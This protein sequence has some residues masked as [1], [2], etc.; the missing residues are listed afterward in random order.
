MTTLSTTTPDTTLRETETHVL[1]QRASR[2]R[3]TFILPTRKI[4]GLM[5]SP[6]PT[7][8]TPIGGNESDSDNEEIGKSMLVLVTDESENRSTP[9]HVIDETKEHNDEVG[10]TALTS[11]LYRT[12]ANAPIPRNPAS[13]ASM[14]SVPSRPNNSSTRRY[15]LNLQKKILAAIP[16]NGDTVDN[17][18][19]EEAKT[20]ERQAR[21]A[22]T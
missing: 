7:V 8:L 16:T 6:S 5:V 13:R 12:V 11:L 17:I 15:S 22:S 21:A 19:L 14:V 3:S 18:A 9:I 10:I 20:K 4:T 2:F 1:N